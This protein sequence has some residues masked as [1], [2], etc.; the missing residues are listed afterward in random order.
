M[1][2]RLFAPRFGIAYRA[3]SSL[4]LRAGYGITYDPFSLQRPLRTNYPV[5]LINNFD[6]PDAFYWAG[7]LARGIPAPRVPDLGNGVLDVPGTFAVVTT[8]KNFDRGYLQSW[9]FTIQ[10]QFRWNF[11]G[12][13][14][15]VATRSTRQLG[16]LDVN[17]G[18]IIGL[19]NA[20]RP[21]QA[22][23][24]RTAA[25]TLVTPFG[26]SQY[27]SLQATLQRR[28]SQGLQVEASYTWSKT[29]GYNINS[30]G[31][32]NFV[33]AMPYFEMNRV[34][35]DYDRPHMLHISNIWD[36]PF[37]KGKK[38]A[39]SGPLA[40]IAGGWQI[41]QLWSF[42]SGPP[43]SVSAS[44][45]SL[46]LPG[47]SQRA[48]QVKPTVQKLGATGRNMSFFDPFAFDSV[49]EPRF[50]TAGYRSLR[51]PGIVNWDFGVTRRFR[52]TERVALHFRMEAFNF[53]NT[54]HFGNP[55]G[56]V[57]NLDANRAT[58]QINR[59]NGYTEVTG[60]TN[61]A[62]DGI[63]ERQFRFGLRFSF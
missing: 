35:A 32:P 11:T 8:P 46:N 9:N 55:G 47:A 12:Q 36:L 51:G 33:Q 63:D 50:G 23:Y 44:G 28:F 17:Q 3:T 14:G 61:L 10:K 2:K 20:G 15:Y 26:T 29:I 38:L 24:G 31:G 19:G 53:S 43:F 59:L 49:T 37:G 48:D 21:L 45:T 57:S 25:T 1:S 52:L 34:I 62:R 42:Y 54:P 7:E 30:D 40:H 60:V 22:K 16:Y 41:N 4:V 39:S 58:G 13:A 6:A 5:L 18:Q 56:N 27:N